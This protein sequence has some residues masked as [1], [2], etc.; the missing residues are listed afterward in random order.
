M[1]IYRDKNG[2]TIEEKTDTTQNRTDTTQNTNTTQNRDETVIPEIRLLLDLQSKPR[3]LWASQLNPTR[4]IT[5]LHE[6][7]IHGDEE[8]LALLL[9]ESADVVGF[10]DIHDRLNERTPL[11]YAG[12]AEVAALLIQNGAKVKAPDKYGSTPLHGAAE[13]GSD[14][15]ARLLIEKGADVHARDQ[16][17]DTPLHW[18]ARRGK[19]KVAA[20]LIQEGADIHARNKSDCTPL[21]YAAL[22]GDEVVAL[23]IQKG[24][25]VNARDEDGDTPR[26]GWWRRVTTRLRRF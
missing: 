11:Y 15:I 22:G 18:A 26:I 24:A 7:A 9:Q 19:D 20:L 25:D 13:K 10:V 17:G 3:P 2:H 21:H 23:L 8:R 16:Y 1:P 4:D 5:P 12:S 6:A 14:K